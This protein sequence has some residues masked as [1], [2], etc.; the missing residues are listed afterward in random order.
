MKRFTALLV[1]FS[2]LAVFDVIVLPSP[3]PQPAPPICY[4]DKDG[5]LICY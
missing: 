3:A 1:L 4:Y 2:L 5:N